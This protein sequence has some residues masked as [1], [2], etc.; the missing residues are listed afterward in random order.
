MTEQGKYKILISDRAKQMLGIHISY[1]ARVNKD[2]ARAKKKEIMSAIRS[3]SEMPERC[4]FLDKPHIPPNRYHK[5]FVADW[6]LILYQIR[7][8]TVY[9]D[10]IVDCR[11]HEYSWLLEE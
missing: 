3:L 2:A 6:Y 1:I 7:D 9:V 8:D 11:S 4:P 5:M 10:F